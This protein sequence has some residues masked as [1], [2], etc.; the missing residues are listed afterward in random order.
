M[1]DEPTESPDKPIE[2]LF[3]KLPNILMIMVDQLRYPEPGDGGFANPMKEILSFLG[4]LEGNAYAEHFPGFCK[5]REH[6]VVFTDHMIAESACIPSRASIFTGQYGPRTGVT[7]TDGLFKSGNA[8]NFPWLRH[9]GAPTIGDWFRELGYSTHYFGKWHVSDPLD[10]TLRAYGFEDWELSW[11]EPHGASTNNMGAYRDFQFAD[12]ACSFLQARGLGV[13]FDRTSAQLS[14]DF[15]NSSTTPPTRPFLAVCSFTNPHD[16]AVYPSLTRALRPATYDAPTRTWLPQELVGPG[17]S[18]PVPTQGT[19]SA[20]PTQGTFRIP[21]NPTGFPQDC[22]TPSPT[23]DEDLLENNKPSAQYDYSLKC[24]IGLAAKVGLAAAQA[25]VGDK[26]EE[27][28][29]ERAVEATLASAIPFQLQKDAAGAALGFLQYYGFAIAMVDRHILRVLE[30]LERSGLKDDTLVVFTAD[31]GEYG[32][33]HGM[34]ME[35]WHGAYRETV[36]VPF[37]VSNPKINESPRPVAIHAQTSHV[38]ILPT[39]LGL[40]TGTLAKEAGKEVLDLAGVRR[41]LSKTHLA[42]PLPGIDLSPVI[43]QRKGPVL[44]PDGTP[45]EGTLFVTDDMITEPLP[46]D[47]DPHNEQ[48][49]DQY[50]VFKATVDHVRKTYTALTPGPVVQPAH[51]RALRSGPWKLVR[52]CDPWSEKPVA[53]QWELYNLEVDPTEKTNL[54][55]AQAAVPTV[56]PEGQLPPGLTRAGIEAQL[57]TMTPELAR[58]EAAFLSPYPSSYP[59]AGIDAER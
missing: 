14:V 38:D 27:T 20:E 34:M 30:T 15:P 3:S 43:A 4:S 33:S 41:R 39:L 26:D 17:G 22:A 50:R 1:T 46:K 8:S 36:H 57:K 55:V 42:A 29:L 52:Y 2:A 12:L 44:W 23:Q 6:A 49:W 5:L 24:G 19:Y 48:G 25:I 16:I 59:T 54:V 58:Q 35:K 56:I 28:I 40:A 13:P 47:D 31:H 37:L 53:D 32:A 21:L 9:D 11:P 18:V 7:Q 51:V 10:H 45:R